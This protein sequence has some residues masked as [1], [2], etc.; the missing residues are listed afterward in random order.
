MSLNLSSNNASYFYNWPSDSKS[1]I[2]GEAILNLGLSVLSNF[3]KIK[4]N[5]N[6]VNS[7][8]ITDYGINKY[9]IFAI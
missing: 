7:T 1:N 9:G 3:S 6:N 4:E 5:N 8:N 2:A